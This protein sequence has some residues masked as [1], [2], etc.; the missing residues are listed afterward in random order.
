MSPHSVRAH[1]GWV[2]TPQRGRGRSEQVAADDDPGGRRSSREPGADDDLPTGARR[3]PRRPAFGL[4]GVAHLL[5][6]PAV[7]VGDEILA[8]RVAARTGGAQFDGRLHLLGLDIVGA[9]PPGALA[10]QQAVDEAAHWSSAH[11]ASS[12]ILRSHLYCPMLQDL[13]VRDANTHLPR[14]LA[15]RESLQET[16]FQDATIVVR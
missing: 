1:P 13:G 6:Q 16:E 4:R 5:G 15:N 10:L 3:P 14:G 8:R 12:L 9:C 11:S 7:Q 2:A